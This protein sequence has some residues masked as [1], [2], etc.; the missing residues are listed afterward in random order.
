M[1]CVSKL[2]ITSINYNTMTLAIVLVSIEVLVLDATTTDA[3]AMVV[4]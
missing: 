3:F 1:S 4:M 2:V